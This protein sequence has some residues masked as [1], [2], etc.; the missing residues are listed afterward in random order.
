MKYSREFWMCRII[1]DTWSLKRVINVS[2]VTGLWMCLIWYVR[3]S[4][5][6]DNYYKIATLFTGSSLTRSLHCIVQNILK[7]SFILTN[8][9]PSGIIIFDSPFH[10]K[11]IN[12]IFAKEKF[13]VYLFFFFKFDYS[14]IY[15]YWNNWQL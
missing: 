10:T 5:G 11:K 13:G 8:S 2:C 14:L 6:C 15:K 9:N 12:C 7:Y 4:R 3:S 1:H